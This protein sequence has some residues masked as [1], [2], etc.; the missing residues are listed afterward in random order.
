MW[1]GW[2]GEFKLGRTVNAGVSW[3]TIRD[4]WGGQVGSSRFARVGQH[5]WHPGTWSPSGNSVRSTDGGTT[6]LDMDSLGAIGDGEPF[7][8]N[9]V[10]TL[11][12]WAI[13]SRQSIR[14]T[15]DGGDSWTI[16]ATDTD[17]RMKRLKM[18]SLN[19]GWAISDSELCKTTDGGTNWQSVMTQP[20]LRAIAF[21]DSSH[22]A[23]VGLGGLLLRTDDAGKTWIRDSSDFTSDLYDVCMLDSTHAWA[24]GQYGLVLGFGDW[25]IGVDEARGRARPYTLAAAVAVRPN[26]CRDRATVE[27][28]RPLVRPVQVT[29]VDVA[30][31]VQ[32]AIPAPTGVRSVELALQS[33]PSGIYFVRAGSGPAARLVVQ[34]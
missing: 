31:R 5:I 2:M 28:S 11:N 18:T 32:R 26:P 17:V 25:A 14:R 29:L 20:G 12:G 1:Y 24:V 33:I 16:V 21:C 7:D 4:F 3:D 9:F 6:W 22:G 15:T 34:R 27:F 30:G 13:A 10:D 19:I 23:I 8:I